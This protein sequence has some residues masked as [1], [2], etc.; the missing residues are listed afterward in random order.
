MNTE[1]LL[2]FG[3]ANG[4]LLALF[5]AAAVDF[6]LAWRRS[7]GQV[8]ALRF[9]WREEHLLFGSW[10]E[11]RRLRWGQYAFCL[12]LV[13]YE[14]TVVFC[15]SM[16]REHWPW[17]QAQ[18]APVL[19]TVMYLA[20]FGKILLGT[21]YNWRSLG[22][23]G[24]LYFIARWVYFNGQ[25][26]WFLGLAVVLL[27]AKDVP[28]RR[29]MKAFLGCGVPTLALVEILHFAGLIAPG[30]TS[31]R[32]GSFRL[33]FGYG[34]PNTFGGIVFGL[35]LA[36]VLL[37]R[38]K[39]CWGEI[40][41]VAAVGI[42]L[43][44]GPASRSAA[45]CTLLLAVLLAGA[46]LVK[47]RPV[48]RLGAFLVAALVPLEVGVSLIL[49]LFVVKVGPW[50]NDIG[51]AW[52]KRLDDLLTCRISLSWAAYRV[53]DIKIA[54]QMLTDWPVLDNIFVYLLFQF[55]PVMLALA[56]ILLMAALYGH[57]R[58]GRWQEVTCLIA[59]LLYGYME[60][61]V[62]HITSNPAALLLC[63]AI[64]ALPRARWDTPQTT[65]P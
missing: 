29:A 47:S 37:R 14:F 6:S 64:F 52:L 46:R 33:M 41:A 12:G 35:V 50:A 21:R 1:D 25:N 16:A 31:E 63:G 62:L 51:P 4:L 5:A 38:A 34:H 53:F 7:G 55:G 24:A 36:W 11:S 45:L 56:A 9:L 18:L 10:G 19:D 61:Q 42:F 17:L 58:C 48:G 60:T 39:L 30:T 15:N 3:F 22:L 57:A 26:I 49:P 13:L 23:A 44:V 43:Q 54:G 59:M 40:A 8:P 27:A 20:F 28:L 2:L 65:E 32:D